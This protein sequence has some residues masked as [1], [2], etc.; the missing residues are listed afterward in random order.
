MILHKRKQWEDIAARFARMTDMLG[1]G[2]DSGILETVIALNA[3]GIETSA[4]CEGHLDHGTGAPWIDIQAHSAGEQSIQV[5]EMFMQ[6]DKAF[7]EQ[8][9]PEETIDALFAEAHQ[10]QDRVKVIHLEQRKALMSYL[11]AFYAVRRVPYD[12]QLAI[13][14]RDMSGRARLES[15]GADFQSVA[16]LEMRVQKLAEYQEE[17]QAF[18]EF[19]KQVY[20]DE[21]K[22]A[23]SA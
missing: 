12:W 23:K 11:T 17:M 22:E 3:L 18:T 7:E 20:F 16:P 9:L 15:H 13:H 1:T 5:A 21:A 10:E 4:S 2:I 14:P 6:A 8:V 19:L